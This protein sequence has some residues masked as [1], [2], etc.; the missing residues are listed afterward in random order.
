MDSDTKE[1]ASNRLLTTDDVATYLNIAPKTLRNLRCPGG[2][3]RFVKLGRCCRYRA[4]DV[5]AF[6]SSNVRLSTSDQGGR[7]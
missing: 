4:C 7:A 5:E 2:G 1:A 6:I 3:P